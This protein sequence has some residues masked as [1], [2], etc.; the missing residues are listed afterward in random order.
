MLLKTFL[1]PGSGIHLNVSRL[2]LFYGLFDMGFWACG[3]FH[4]S[5]LPWRG[6]QS[7]R[8]KE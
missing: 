8:G 7:G 5:D 4:V 6:L 3:W 2:L 1:Q